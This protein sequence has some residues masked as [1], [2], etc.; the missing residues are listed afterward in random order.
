MVSRTP[1]HSDP[2]AEAAAL[3]RRIGFATLVLA[4]P[5]AAL[6]A[7]RATVVLVPL[8]TA[9][10]VLAAV[11]DGAGPG[12]VGGLKRLLLSRAGIAALVLAGWA[13]LSILWTPFTL[14]ASEKIVN[15][16]IVVVIAALGA[17]ALPE[18][19]RAS[20]LYLT[21]IGAGGAA[22]F[23]L[24]LSSTGAIDPSTGTDAEGRSVERGLVVLS[25][26]VWPA[27]AWLTSRARHASALI[28]ALVT[29]AAAIASGLAAPMIALAAGAIVYAMA[30]VA[31][32]PT[33]RATAATMALLLA[34]APLL[35]FLLRPVLKS[36]QGP[37]YP[38]ATQLKI[39]GELV[40]AEPIKL[41]TGHGLD[42][43][44]RSRLVGL[45]PVEAPRSLPFEIWYELGLVGGVAAAAALY[46]AIR[47]T[48]RMHPPLTP[49]ALAAFV[50]AFAIASSGAANFQAWWITALGVVVLTFIA[51]ERGQFRTSRPKIR[52][53]TASAKHS[54]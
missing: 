51:A 29:A 54:L 11:L 8:G 6:V 33:I 36:F 3:L 50:S 42:T 53:F 38:W 44:L 12:L 17:A 2:A 1:L 21:A 35:P 31:L 30:S 37:L 22:L 48:Q 15:I 4:V 32:R 9:L 47:G 16:A 18:R 19:M 34:L 27:I 23:A 25:V 46:F 39:W 7:R 14:T 13:A 5:L 45:L 41:I 52:L 24:W 40:R 49:G 43:S 20:N 10:L 26:A 28:L